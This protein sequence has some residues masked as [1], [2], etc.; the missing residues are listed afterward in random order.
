ML[1][2]R[3]NFSKACSYARHP[4][5]LRPWTRQSNNTIRHME[6]GLKSL[7]CLRVV[8]YLTRF[9]KTYLSFEVC[10]LINLVNPVLDRSKTTFL[11]APC[12]VLLCTVEYNTCTIDDLYVVVFFIGLSS[13]RNEWSLTIM[14]RPILMMCEVLSGFCSIHLWYAA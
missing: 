11:I 12:Y 3:N 9:D 1:P 13:S 6:W 10:S 5:W 14:D 2:R 4:L 7:V 8:R